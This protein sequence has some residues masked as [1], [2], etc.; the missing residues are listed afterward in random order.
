[1]QLQKQCIKLRIEL[2][3]L[4]HIT[5]YSVLINITKYMYIIA[6]DKIYFYDL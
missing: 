1:L 5:N 3:R 2:G 4:P 6:K